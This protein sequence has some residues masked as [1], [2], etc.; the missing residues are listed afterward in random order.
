MARGV[1]L[2]IAL[3]LVVG[4]GVIGWRFIGQS[5][6]GAFFLRPD[7][8]ALVALGA[9]LYERECASCHGAQL[10]GQPNWRMR[11]ADGRL[12]APPHDQSGHTWHHPD[13]VLHALTKYGPAAVVGNDYETDMPAYEELL[14]DEEITA[15]LSYIKST[16]PQPIR[17]RHD[18]INQANR[19]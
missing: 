2:F 9:G 14:S 19:K 16:W 8:V 11:K 5:E 4:A 18:A 6:K 1:V 7:D 17:E 10:E 15:V 3:G 12:P 13:E